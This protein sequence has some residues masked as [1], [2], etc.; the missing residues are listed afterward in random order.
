MCH[1]EFS[2]RF[3]FICEVEYSFETSLANGENSSGSL[4]TPEDRD[5]ENLPRSGEPAEQRTCLP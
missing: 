2:P 4:T 1:R 3:I 5:T